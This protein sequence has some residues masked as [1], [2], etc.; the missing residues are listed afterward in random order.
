MQELESRS[1]SH[2]VIPDDDFT[3]VDV[4]EG[5]VVLE[6]NQWHDR[7]RSHQVST[8]SFCPAEARLLAAMLTRHAQ[9]AES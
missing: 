4:V 9:F 5:N 2:D 7:S 8:L 3:V 1:I 6:T